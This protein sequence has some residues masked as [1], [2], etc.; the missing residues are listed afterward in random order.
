MFFLDLGPEFVFQVDVFLI[1]GGLVTA[2]A[3][4]SKS[5]LN[6]VSLSEKCSPQPA[7]TLPRNLSEMYIRSL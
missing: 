2:A 1:P 6:R 7:S 4:L 5:Q 3:S